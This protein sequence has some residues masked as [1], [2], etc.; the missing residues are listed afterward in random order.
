MMTC[1]YYFV[2]RYS[3][4]I[5]IVARS[6]TLCASMSEVIMIA[7]RDTI[8][9]VAYC[10]YICPMFSPIGACAPFIPDIIF[11]LGKTI[12]GSASTLSFLDSLL[13]L[14]GMNIYISCICSSDDAVC[15]PFYQKLLKPS[16]KLY[17]LS[18]MIPG[19]FSIFSDPVIE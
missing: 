9:D 2:C 18:I 5:I 15:S 11:S 10:F 13:T 12:S 6:L 17:C 8:G 1:S 4:G 16:F 14:I 19:I 7:S 3:L